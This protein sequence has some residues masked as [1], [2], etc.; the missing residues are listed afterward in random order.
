MYELQAIDFSALKES[1]FLN[2][3]NATKRCKQVPT[4]DVYVFGLDRP[5]A[6]GVVR[7]PV[8]EDHEIFL[9][10]YDQNAVRRCSGG[11]YFEI[12]LDGELTLPVPTMNSRSSQDDEFLRT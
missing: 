11:D 3:L 12:D 8:D 9:V 4:A 1:W 6:E 5:S 10:S 2:Q 7:L